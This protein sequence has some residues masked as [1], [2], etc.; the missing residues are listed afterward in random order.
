MIN[1]GYDKLLLTDETGADNADYKG[2]RQVLTPDFSSALSL[3]YTGRITKDL[4]YFVIP[5]W[6]YLGKQYMTYYNDLVQD[7][8]HLLNANAG[9]RYKNYEARFWAKNITDSQYLS[10]AYANYRMENSP[11]AFGLPK[12]YGVNL[13]VTF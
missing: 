4:S 3:S 1:T 13:K 8:F 5:E 7:P 12:T 6:K 11:V 10:F 2:N 9:L